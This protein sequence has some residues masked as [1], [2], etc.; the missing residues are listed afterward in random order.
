MPF[1]K[2]N[3]PAA[4]PGNR[5]K[6]FFSTD[7]VEGPRDNLLTPYQNAITKT[8]QVDKTPVASFAMDS[9]SGKGVATMDDT[10]DL[11]AIKRQF[12]QRQYAINDAQVAWYGTNGFIGYQLCSMIAQQ[13]LINKACSMPGKDAIRNGFDITVED[14]STVDPKMIKELRKL[15]KKM[16]LTKNLVQFERMKRVFGIRH[17]IFVVE[18]SDPDYYAKPFN[19]KGVAKGSYK[20]ISQVDPY[21]IAPLLDDDSGRDPASMDFY[22]PTWWKING[23]LYHKSHLVIARGDEV[24]DLLKPT[25]QFGGISTVQQ[26]FERVYAAERT[27]N[28]APLLAMTKR[29]ITLHCDLDMAAADPAGFEARLELARAYRDNYGTRV[30]GLEETIEQYDTALADLD[31]TIM[32][33]YQLV[34]AAARVPITKLMGTVPKGF[35]STGEYDESNY[36]E[37]LETIQ[38]HDLTPLVNRHH[39]LCILSEV[40]PAAPFEVDITWKPL[41]AVSAKERAE[42]NKSNAETDTQLVA[43][44]A[45]D[46][47]E[48]RD[49]L[50]KDPDSGYT[51]LKGLPD[52]PD[53]DGADDPEDDNAKADDDKK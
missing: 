9:A 48:V 20:G 53:D 5:A 35:N 45:I 27:A 17:A 41:D 28:E 18:S 29:L 13:W 7:G 50:V 22:E 47:I 3:K 19:P 43:A 31:A 2:K 36:H 38:T 33:Q 4:A 51:G 34:A 23:K 52:L 12:A 32:T 42:I 6:G 15:D 21:W 24:T 16:N 8:F 26:I 1:W 25:Y 44:G 39:M 40:S 14:D 46:G 37:E 11:S 49:R 10:T 30:L